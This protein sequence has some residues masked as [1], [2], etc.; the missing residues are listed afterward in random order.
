M[1]IF[2]TVFID[3]IGFGIV[4]P[5]LPL[6]A[7]KFG[8]SGLTVGL[9]LMSYSLMQFIFTPI[10]GRLSDRVGRR[11]MLI[12]SLA[13]SGV[14]YLIW[15]FS[16]S[17]PMLFL[18]RIVAGAGNA[19]LAVAQAYIADVTTAENR[20][21]GMGLVGAA[22]G[23]GFVLGPAIG[24]AALSLGGSY[25]V[26]GLLAA[27][28]SLLDLVLTF[29]LLPEPEKRTQAGH[30]R[31][32]L[33]PDF[34]W[35]TLSTA[36]LRV[37]LAIFFISTFS[38]SLM[39]ATLVLLTERQFS[40]SAAQNGWMFAYIGLV[41]V[42]VQGGMIG[43]LSKRF[44]EQK[45]IAAGTAL[46]AAGLLL[47]PATTTPAVLYGALALL[48]IGSGINNPSN[49]SI[50][51]KLAPRDKVGGVL[52]VGQSL[53]TLGRILGPLAGGASF[54]YVGVASPYLIGASTM[55]LA[56]VLSLLLPDSQALATLVDQRH[57]IEPSEAKT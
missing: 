53:S 51:S 33:E 41:M 47:T 7:E 43:R 11:P 20:A 1:L 15:G 14:G 34:Y 19:N 29:F 45:L 3:L 24:G 5:L 31:F 52:G 35:K 27:G 28:F 44:G 36:S 54:Q 17:L 12:L 57:R 56:F 2:F 55:L 32:S 30:E 40:F 38:F 23:L 4:I 18:S 49:Q 39:E 10:W 26:A 13:A 46:V 22:F 48:A 50:L 42:F 16:A 9:L 21:R 25:Q 8:A 37:P 6:F